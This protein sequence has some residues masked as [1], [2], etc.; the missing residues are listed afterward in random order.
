M[1]ADGRKGLLR[2][3]GA[4]VRFPRPERDLLLSSIIAT[5]ETSDRETT[6][7][8]RLNLKP[9]LSGSGLSDPLAPMTAAIL[10]S[11]ILTFV[12]PPKTAEALTTSSVSFAKGLMLYSC[13]ERWAGN[14]FHVQ[15]VT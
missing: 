6:E 4:V 11:G 5:F 10:D 13:S 9:A 14:G 8:F 7:S 2:S 1:I 12:Q 3:S 15:K